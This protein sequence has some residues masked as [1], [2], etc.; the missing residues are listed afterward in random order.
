MISRILPPSEFGYLNDFDGS[1]LPWDGG[2]MHWVSHGIP[3]IIGILL[4]VALLCTCIHSSSVPCTP[5]DCNNCLNILNSAPLSPEVGA[6]VGG[7]IGV[8]LKVGYDLF[9]NH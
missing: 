8:A 7:A 4:G 6:V 5:S 1:R 3:G 9:Q 2:D